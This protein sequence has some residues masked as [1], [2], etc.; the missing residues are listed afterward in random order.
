M[1]TVLVA[2]AQWSFD[3]ETKLTAGDLRYYVDRQAHAAQCI[4][5]VEGLQPTTVTVP[6]TVTLEGSTYRVVSIADGAFLNATELTEAYLQSPELVMEQLVFGGKIQRLHMAAAVPPELTYYLAIDINNYSFPVVRVYV[7]KGSLRAYLANEW[8]AQHVILEDG[9]EQSLSVSTQRVGMLYDIIAAQDIPLKGIHHLTVSGPLND[10]DIRIIRDSVPNLF[11]LDISQA[12]IRELPKEGFRGC[13]FSSIQLPTTL[14]SVGSTAFINCQNLEE[15]VI[16]EGVLSADNAVSNCP[17]LHSIDLPSTLLSAKRFLSSYNF[18]DDGST[19]SCT[20]TCR[21]FFPP[22]AGSYAVFTYGNVDI[23]VRVPAVSAGAYASASGWKDLTQETFSGMP[24]S[25]TV[26]GKQV[27]NTDDLPSGYSP[28]INLSQFGDYGGYGDNNAFGLLTVKGSKA[29]NVGAFTAFTDLHDDRNYTGRYGCELLTEAPMTAQSVHLDLVIS[30]DWWYFLSFPFDVKVSDIVT[31]KDIKHW[32]IR[33]YSG[34]NRAAMRGEQWIDV[35]YSATL[36]ANRGYIWQV[37]TDNTGEYTRSNLS[38]GVEATAN[39]I[40]NMFARED[41]SIPL[42]EYASTYEHN[43][44][45]NLVG[46]PYPCYYRIGSLKQK[47]PITVWNGRTWDYDQ[48]RTYSPVDDANKELHPYEA[49]FLQKP[50]NASALVFG[51]EGRVAFGSNARA[52]VSEDSPAENGNRRL[53]NLTLTANGMEDYTRVVLNPDAKTSY[54]LECDASKFF[55]QSEQVPQ[56]YTFIGTEPC[57][58]NERPEGDGMVRMGVR[59]A[60]ATTCVLSIESLVPTDAALPIMLADQLTGSLTD[61]SKEAYTFLSVPGRDDNRFV[62][63]VGAAAATGI[64]SVVGTQQQTAFPTMNL[65]GQPVGS[66]YKGIVI[67][68]GKLTIKR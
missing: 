8:W 47:M 23:K 38:I 62:L 35:P 9:V 46:N 41:V 53:I 3:E 11:T 59:T 40:N 60:A 39:T 33:S 49:F 51:A 54:E 45:W 34:K 57:A 65:Q 27:L 16:P 1:M 63:Y 64:Q 66:D 5:L 21:A 6:A 50:A 48:Y 56:L 43:V 26:L 28:N 24:T 4:G 42:S 61:L 44:S 15:L 17:K 12:V 68:N 7:P 19:Y 13:R 67:E 18:N 32:I 25:I 36:E 30:E 14:T 31:D 20:V 29:L 10:D 2:K 22:K 55:S 52:S 58:I 37:S